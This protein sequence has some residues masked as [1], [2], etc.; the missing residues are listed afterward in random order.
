[1]TLRDDAARNTSHKN[2]Y[3]AGGDFYSASP[4]SFCNPLRWRMMVWQNSRV[5][6]MTTGKCVPKLGD[7]HLRGQSYRERFSEDKSTSQIEHQSKGYSQ[8]T[9]YKRA[10]PLPL[11]SMLKDSFIWVSDSWRISTFHSFPRIS[12]IREFPKTD[13]H[14]RDSRE[15]LLIRDCFQ[16]P[17]RSFISGSDCEEISNRVSSLLL[18]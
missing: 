5:V 15:F 6:A 9:I 2:K 18:P 10:I 7:P 1:M 12:L 3:L 8:F 16:F 14:M 4:L 17:E 11:S 13:A